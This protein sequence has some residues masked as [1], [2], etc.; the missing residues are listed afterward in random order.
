MERA[1]GLCVG[2]SPPALGAQGG[3]SADLRLSVAD[4]CCRISQHRGCCTQRVKLMPTTKQ[5][6]VATAEPHCPSEARGVLAKLL[7][8]DS[9]W[10]VS[11]E[12]VQEFIAALAAAGFIRESRS[13][14]S[15]PSY[16]PQATVIIIPLRWTG[17]PG[18][19]LKLTRAAR[20]GRAGWRGTLLS[21]TAA[22]PCPSATRRG[23][24][25][26]PRLRA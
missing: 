15:K 12:S 21:F 20:G 9:P 6:A 14:P 25:R 22:R 2:R 7:Q 10:K 26:P 17:W 8:R 23:H 11:K 4:R 19:A 24:P 1:S 3:R 16:D 5:T 13:A 18:A